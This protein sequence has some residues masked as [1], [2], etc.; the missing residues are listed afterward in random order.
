MIKNKKR[1][2]I[3]QNQYLLGDFLKNTAK[4]ADAGGLA[5]GITQIA[6]GDTA[7]GIFNTVGSI[8]EGIPVFGGLIGG[9][10]KGIGGI[11][12]MGA[13]RRKELKEFADKSAIKQ[14]EAI[15][16]ATNF[17]NSV[18]NKI[19]PDSLGTN[20][21]SAGGIINTVNPNDDLI[22]INTGGT[23]EENPI[24]GVPV[25]S[26]EN[27]TMN[28]VEQGETIMKD[29]VYSNRIYL[30]EDIN[31]KS[32]Y[33]LPNSLKGKSFAKASEI[34]NNKF[35]DREDKTSLETKKIFLDRLA[36][37][38][39]QLKQEEQQ[40]NNAN[41]G[42][43]R[44]D[45][46]EVVESIQDN[47]IMP[48]NENIE[49]QKQFEIGGYKGKD[50][51]T[52]DALRVNKSYRTKEL[53]DQFEK[54]IDYYIESILNNPLGVK[55]L[56]SQYGN[57][58]YYP[59]FDSVQKGIRL[60]DQGFVPDNN[61]LSEIL[62][63]TLNPFYD[64]TDY[65][66]Y[67]NAIDFLNNPRSYI[68]NTLG[69]DPEIFGQV[70]AGVKNS[71]KVLKNIDKVKRLIKSTIGKG[72]VSN[73]KNITSTALSDLRSKYPSTSTSS[74]SRTIQRKPNELTSTR[75]SNR[76]NDNQ[77]I[78]IP[79]QEVPPIGLNAGNIRLALPGKNNG[80]ESL[81][82]IKYLS[83]PLGIGASIYGLNLLG[84]KNS[85]SNMTSQSGNINNDINTAVNNNPKNNI[86]QNP[87]TTNNNNNILNNKKTIRDKIKTYGP[88]FNNISSLDTDIPL[89][90]QETRL[91]DKYKKEYDSMKEGSI[92]KDDDLRKLE[93]KLDRSAAGL[94]IANNLTRLW[95][96]KNPSY[97]EYSNIM[98]PQFGTLY[99]RLTNK[100]RLFNAIDRS[101][102]SAE[103]SLRNLFGNNPG[104]LLSNLGSLYARQLNSKADTALQVEDRDN[105]IKM[106]ID[107][108]NNQ[109]AQRNALQNQ[110]SIL[111]SR[112]LYN[113]AKR[114]Y[115]DTKA[116]LI[117]TLFDNLVEIN[118]DKKNKLFT[119]RLAPMYNN[120]SMLAGMMPQSVTKNR[121]GGKIKRK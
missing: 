76:T 74:T 93:D 61:V 89:D 86:V 23:H 59:G 57:G 94:A 31:L 1:I 15:N 119:E 28:T 92:N 88:S 48:Q 99:P 77:V 14:Q 109:M 114:D 3:K 97:A 18:G 52:L 71:K 60:I 36:N 85:N 30:P 42:D 50:E 112:A 82:G 108:Y 104:A 90:L 110:Q 4:G 53:D 32:E 83:I 16:A 24:G 55:P 47:E 22:K 64:N 87:T 107:Q 75:V 51:N 13:K 68:L 80:R 65:V 19:Y 49:P 79:Y 2:L 63:S 35:K 33:G 9:A 54:N 26:D 21:Y 12:S 120:Y 34:I 98:L 105:Q 5:G 10:L 41:T 117:G 102:R 66:D 91:S 25:G 40:A 96:N 43:L 67:Y 111:S 27:G 69:D 100:A 121:K 103:Y 116:H 39:E 7:G 38:Q 101:A 118:R 106:G 78:D 29:F 95:L 45:N 81:K 46:Q 17:N 11:F 115:E 6:A 20:I 113:Q 62:N 73:Q 44:D 70:E 72:N 56:G 8:A 37:L 84:D 58:Y